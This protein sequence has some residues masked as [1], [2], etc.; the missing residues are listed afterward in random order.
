VWVENAADAEAAARLHPA[1]LLT[2]SAALAEGLGTGVLL[3]PAPAELDVAAI[4]V[5]PPFVRKRVRRRFGLP[6]EMVIDLRESAAH[7]PAGDGLSHTALAVTAAAIVPA[8]RLAEARA[9]GTPAVTDAEA[10][11]A[12]AASDGVEVRVGAPDNLARIADLLAADETQAAM[13]SRAGRRLVEQGREP[14]RLALEIARRLGLWPPAAP[15]WRGRVDAELAEL[16]TLAGARLRQRLETIMAGVSGDPP[17][18]AARVTG[19]LSRH[20]EEAALTDL[21]AE[22][23]RTYPALPEP[24]L[25]PAPRTGLSRRAR[26]LAGRVIRRRRASRL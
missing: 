17:Y 6:E 25:P 10:A 8:G 18:A 5:M 12:V 9:W 15:D 24:Y 23:A 1:L 11:A 2:G 20:L 4:P 21:R 22:L 16:R 7:A 19:A 26:R 3:V 14:D 13:L